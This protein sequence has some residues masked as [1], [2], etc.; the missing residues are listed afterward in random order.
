MCEDDGLARA[1][2]PLDPVPAGR[3]GCGLD[4]YVTLSSG[5]VFTG[6]KP[7]RKFL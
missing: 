4:D 6:Y 2:I 1:S 5:K 7:V 3:L